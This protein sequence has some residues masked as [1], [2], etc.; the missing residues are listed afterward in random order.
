LSSANQENERSLKILLSY[1]ILMRGNFKEDLPHILALL[2]LCLALLLVGTK[3]GLVRCSDL[4]N[5]YCDVYYTILGKP[6]I[7]VLHDSEG[8]GMGD[9]RKLSRLITDAYNIPVRL[10]EMQKLSRGM[11]EDYNV[12]IVEHARNIPTEQLKILKDFV[13]MDHGRLVWVGDSGTVGMEDDQVCKTMEYSGQYA[14]DGVAYPIDKHEYSVCVKES[15]VEEDTVSA[16]TLA[17]KTLLVEAA[18]QKLQDEC[19]ALGGTLDTVKTRKGFSCKDAGYDSV[20]L[21]WDNEDGFVRV[22]NPWARGEYEL[23]GKETIEPGLNFGLTVLG[24]SFITDDYAVASFEEYN[25]R[26]TEVQAQL[27]KAHKVFAECTVENA[28]EGCDSSGKLLVVKADLIG[29]SE[30]LTSID[31]VVQ[32]HLTSLKSI[33]QQKEVKEDVAGALYAS[34]VISVIEGV[35]FDVDVPS[36]LPVKIVELDKT[37][38]VQLI[39]DS[40]EKFEAAEEESVVKSQLNGMIDGLSTKSLGLE[41]TISKLE[42]DIS[43]YNA[44]S[45]VGQTSLVGA[46]SADVG[47]EEEVRLLMAFSSPLTE[48][49]GVE[50]LVRAGTE[51][52]KLKKEWQSLS[53]K[54]RKSSVCEG[55]LGAASDGIDLFEG[56]AGVL[57]P[58][59]QSMALA[60]LLAA[61]ETHPLVRGV[62]SGIDLKKDGLPVPFVLVDTVERD[63]HTVTQL[64]VTPGYGGK[65]LWTGISVKD[66]KFATHA[67]GKGAVVFYAFPPETDEIFVRNLIEFV[68]Y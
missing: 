22:L 65:T 19:E 37:G 43:S 64:K 36:D 13:F 49:E 44:C 48:Q 16:R 32:G 31:A 53:S 57:N 23:L 17:K 2:L 47:Y 35:S 30:S 27:N 29:V 68:L 18:L 60:S 24:L 55:G 25:A 14:I 42:N 28:N 9:V 40:L 4:G 6:Q 56:A 39:V 51:D 66:P 46:I 20:Y 15:D 1:S 62:S 10:V 34:D 58:G 8:Q 12:V 50:A 11:L 38:S 26:I 63:A 7:M 33:K 3:A 45:V 67:F 21:K 5:S 61:D 54:L 41:S 59:V 52:G